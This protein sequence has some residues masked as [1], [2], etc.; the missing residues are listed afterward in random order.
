M[1][2]SGKP[3]LRQLG[4]EL[5]LP[6]LFIRPQSEISSITTSDV[7]VLN[8]TQDSLVGSTADA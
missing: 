7:S 5:V 6:L 2:S 1:S 8:V 4:H 3:E